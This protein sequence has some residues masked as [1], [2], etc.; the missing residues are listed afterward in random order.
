[1]LVCPSMII[2][3]LLVDQGYSLSREMKHKWKTSLL[4]HMELA[5][6]LM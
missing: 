1:M 4:R 3:S 6:V 5:T 2:W